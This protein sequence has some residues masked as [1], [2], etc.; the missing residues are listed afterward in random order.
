MPVLTEK[1]LSMSTLLL[2]GVLSFVSMAVILD[3]FSKPERV[4]LGH[5]TRGTCP[6]KC[7]DDFGKV[8]K[9]S[10]GLA[11]RFPQ[12]ECDGRTIHDKSILDCT[13]PIL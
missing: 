2:I 11:R 9:V 8:C 13:C 6:E 3:T 4:L 5:V 12:K 7:I 10:P 1:I